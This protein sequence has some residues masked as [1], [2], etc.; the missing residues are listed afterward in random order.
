M[1]RFFGIA[2]LAASLATMASPARAEHQ[3][4]SNDRDWTPPSG[5]VC[6]LRLDRIYQPN[7]GQ[8]IYF[9]ITNQTSSRVQYTV[10]VVLRRNNQ[11]VFTG[12]IFVDNANANEQSTAGTT[13]RYSGTLRGT[14]IQLRVTSCSLR[15][16]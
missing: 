5:N 6:T 13:N 11:D 2:A 1:K 14:R 12:S 7:P 15:A 10:A 8:P 9:K 3:W 16:S 4:G